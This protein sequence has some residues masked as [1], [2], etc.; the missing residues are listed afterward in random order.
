MNEEMSNAQA[1]QI[2]IRHEEELKKLRDDITYLK[3]IRTNTDGRLNALETAQNALRN[4][5]D[6]LTDQLTSPAVPTHLRVPGAEPEGEDHGAEWPHVRRSQSLC[7]EIRP[8]G[9]YMVP[10]DKQAK[11]VS[12]K[13]EE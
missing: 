10:C 13:E 7:V 6:E 2:V 8:D 3:G 11:D 5:F 12:K 1:K 9:R 4:D